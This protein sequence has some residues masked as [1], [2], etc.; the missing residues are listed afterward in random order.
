MI[1]V[2]LVGTFWGVLTG[3]GC[4]EACKGLE[5]FCLVVTWVYTYVKIHQAVRLKFE[6]FMYGMFSQKKKKILSWDFPG[7]AVVKTPCSQCR[8][9]GFDPCQGTRSHTHAATKEPANR[10]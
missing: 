2:Q 9:P 6:H 8:G 7:G 5:M 1:K 3:R 4:E 10:N